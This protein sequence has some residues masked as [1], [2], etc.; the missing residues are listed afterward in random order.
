MSDTPS[1]ALKAPKQPRS[2]RT[3][4][5]IVKAALEI[6]EEEGP[7]AVTVQA[8]VARARSS[9][10]S[11]YA[12][13]G[14]KDDLLDY[15]GS[16]VWDE[17]LERWQEAV[18]ERA[19]SEMDLAQ[20]AGG[21]VALLFDVRRS[22]ADQLRSLDRLA[23]GSGAYEAFRTRLLGDL[24]ALLLERR[25][26]IVHANPEL[27]VRLGLRAVL[28]VIDSGVDVGGAEPVPKDA[29]LAE[30]RELLI[31]YLTGRPGGPGSGQ[32]DFFDVWG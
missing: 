7:S 27:S 29:L 2:K 24:E 23:D 26:E 10:G 4:E 25:D 31:G 13:F 6:L 14:G 12:R 19:W 9:V 8:V 20:I 16:R 32:V 22:R 21:A 5:R 28:G 15:L 11:F 30:C 3:L 18:A 1:S 17:A